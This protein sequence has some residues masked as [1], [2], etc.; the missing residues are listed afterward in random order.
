MVDYKMGLIIHPKVQM[1]SNQNKWFSLIL[2]SR[3]V[4][5]LKI[6]G[7]DARFLGQLACTISSQDQIS[8]IGKFASNKGRKQ[9]RHI[10]IAS[11]ISY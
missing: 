7:R 4:A 5:V 8:S 11:T 3:G 2:I 9:R 6:I 1:Y 10:P